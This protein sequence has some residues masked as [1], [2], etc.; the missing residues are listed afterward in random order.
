METLDLLPEK[1]EFTIEPQ[2]RGIVGFLL[3]RHFSLLTFTA[4]WDRADIRPS[5]VHGVC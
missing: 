5:I 3:G 2:E 1:R 4:H